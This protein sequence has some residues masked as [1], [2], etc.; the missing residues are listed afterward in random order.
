MVG[1]HVVILLV[2]DGLD[3]VL[4][5]LPLEVIAGVDKLVLL[6]VVLLLDLRQL[7]LQLL[8][9]HGERLHLALEHL[10]PGRR[11]YVPHVGHHGLAE[12]L[13][14]ETMVAVEP[15]MSNV[16]HAQSIVWVV[17]IFGGLN[18]DPSLRSSDSTWL[19]IFHNCSTTSLGLHV[20]LVGG[21]VAVERHGA[22]VLLL[23]GF[24]LL[25]KLLLF[26]FG[27][28]SPH[29]PND[30]SNFKELQI[31]ILVLD[32]VPYLARVPHVRS[33]RFLGRF[34]GLRNAGGKLKK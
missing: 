15:R 31:W 27:K 22:V 33:Q 34:G 19:R 26:V 23:F 14:D 21:C 11:H 25:G 13:V 4:L 24:I 30:F 5:Q 32:R 16:L 7:G 29:L 3:A 10:H 17:F 2:V 6:L 20:G 9:V 28:I 8:L 1:H 18:I 12:N